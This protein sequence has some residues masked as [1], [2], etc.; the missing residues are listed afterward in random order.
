MPRVG[1]TWG[2]RDN[3][4]LRGGLGLYSGGNPN[5]WVA[6][7]WSRDG[8]T[9]VQVREVY[10]NAASIFDGS[11]PTIAGPV[12]GA[13]P[14]VLFD[15]IAAI[16]G[17]AGSDEDSVLISPSYKQPRE[18][19]YSLG[20]TWDTG[21]WDISAD[22]DF[23]YTRLVDSALYTDLSQM[24]VGTTLAGTPIY[25]PKPGAGENNLMLTNAADTAT[26]SVF[27]VVLRKDFDWGLDLL[28]GY[29]YT[30]VE[31]VSPMTSF[32][33]ESSYTNNATNDINNPVAGR[34]QYSVRDRVTLRASYAR[35]FWGDNTTRFTLMGYYGSGQ[36]TTYV[37]TSEGELT[38]NEDFQSTPLY[39]PTGPDDPNVIFAD[40][41]D[42]SGF[43]SFVQ[44]NGLAPGFVSRNSVESKHNSRLD[45]RIDQEIPLYF[46]GLKARAFM[47]IYNFSNML[48]DDWGRQHDDPF[49][50]AGVVDIEVDDSGAFVFN[51]FDP[52]DTTDLE[53]FASLWEI[54]MGLEVNFN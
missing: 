37:M 22:I 25:G 14:Q 15:E 1:F 52:S 53:T 8:L 31:D 21:F 54:R 24:Q 5:V 32:T 45:L 46:D 17:S 42:Q 19:K 43:F 6:N 51:T 29:A 38:V 35:E 44:A 34:S 41:F 9:Q 18:W 20:A 12:G 3:L 33:A 39:V 16:S 36:P 50:S 23:L 47:K 11:L 27:S 30:D 10:R 48:N 4:T 13:I 7:A 28:L 26:G 40:G 2:A 49:F